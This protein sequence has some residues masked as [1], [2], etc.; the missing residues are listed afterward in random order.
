MSL[1]A[2]EAAPEH[3]QRCEVS[4]QRVLRWAH[5]QQYAGYSKFDVFNSPLMRLLSLNNRYVRLSLTAA[6][7]RMPIDLRPL[8]GMQKSRNPKGIAL[9]ALAYLRSHQGDGSVLSLARARELLAWLDANH[10]RGYAGK[11]WGYDHPWQSLHFYAPRYFPNIVVT[12]NVAYAFLEAFEVTGEDS[13]LDVA[14]SVADFMLNDLSAPV[15]TREMRSIGYIPGSD[16]GVLNINGLAAAIFIRIWQHTAE[17]SLLY[18]AHRLIRFLVDKQ[19]D[20]GAWHYAWPPGTSNVRHDNYHTGSVLDWILDY[21][22]RSGDNRFLA[23]YELGLNFYR[24]RLFLPDGAPKWRSD[25]TYPFDI[26]GAAQAIVTFAKAALEHDPTHLAH[27]RRVSLW[28]IENMQSPEGFFHY[29]RGRF[30]TKK[31]TLMRWC[32]AWM[33][34]A[35]S[36]MLLARHELA[37]KTV[38]S[39]AVRF[40]ATGA[41]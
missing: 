5:A 25:K 26:H 33:A 22:R 41:A 7:S 2:F 12:G 13:Y 21:C 24:D 34:Y 32:N 4:L 15:N 31:Y 30:W 10:T 17:P 28:A 39:G 14:R 11:C 36:S 37:S 27:A 23:R 40:D 16:W 35:L 1:R 9:F 8:V 18:E 20:Y 29:Q 3:W 19:T 38:D 6:W